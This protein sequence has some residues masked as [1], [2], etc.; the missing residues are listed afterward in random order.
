[1]HDH[2]HHDF[3]IAEGDMAICPVMNMEVSKSKAE[4]EGLV[5][6]YSGQTYY[7]CCRTCDNLFDKSPVDYA[8]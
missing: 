7:L 6:A 1:M 2:H 4:A 3:T 5:K 8:K